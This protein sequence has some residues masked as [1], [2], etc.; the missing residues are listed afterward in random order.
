M[1]VKNAV[2][3]SVQDIRVTTVTLSHDLADP[4]GDRLYMFHC[5]ICGSVVV[6]YTGFIMSI[7][8]GMEPSAN[9][10]IARCSNIK[11]CTG[12]YLFRYVV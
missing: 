4:N 2:D 7:Y 6:Q 5:P 8:P 12:K 9:F 10:I 3:E 11:R 1:L